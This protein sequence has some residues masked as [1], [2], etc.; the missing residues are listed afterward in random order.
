MRGLAEKIWKQLAPSSTAF[1]AAF[2]RAP[3]E[4]VWIPIR[5][6]SQDKLPEESGGPAR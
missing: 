4:E 2:T 6:F 3:E 1:F 5:T